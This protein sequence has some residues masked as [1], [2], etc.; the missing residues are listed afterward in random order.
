MSALEDLPTEDLAEM[1]LLEQYCLGVSSLQPPS[2]PL[3]AQPDQVFLEQTILPLLLRGLEEL[4]IARPP[5]PL[6]FLAAYLL[7]NNPMR[8]TDGIATQPPPPPP[9]PVD[10]KSTP[11]PSSTVGL[12]NKD[13]SP[14]TDETPSA[15]ELRSMPMPSRREL[16]ALAASRFLKAPVTSNEEVVETKMPEQPNSPRAAGTTRKRKA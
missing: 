15:A 6:A 16:A 10:L 3:Y 5:D 12:N 11:P 8:N 7:G 13:N 14:N 9:P 1:Q 2:L 4:V